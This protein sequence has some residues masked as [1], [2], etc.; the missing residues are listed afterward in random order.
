MLPKVTGSTVISV[1]VAVSMNMA[2]KHQIIKEKLPEYLVA[3]KDSDKGRQSK[4]L[5]AVVEVTGM[6][7]KSVIRA[8]RE[9]QME[10]HQKTPKKRGR[11]RIFTNDCVAA[12]NEV[13]QCAHKICG[14]RLHCCISEYVNILQRDNMWSYSSESTALLLRMSFGSVKHY[15]AQ[16]ARN[17]HTLHRGHSTTK[18]SELKEIIPIRRGPWD[19]PLPGYGEVDTVVHCGLTLFGDYCYSTQYTDVATCWCLLS[20]QWNKGQEA[21]VISIEAM[22]SR[23]PFSVLGLDP[24]SGSEFINWHMKGWCDERGIELTRIRP[25]K[26]NDHARIEQKNRTCIRDYVGYNRLDVRG[27]EILLNELYSYLELYIN[28][29]QPTM[30]YTG[31]HINEHGKTTRR[32]YDRARTPYERVLE[33]SHVSDEVKQKLREVHITLNPKTLLHRVYA[34]H[35]KL[36]KMCQNGK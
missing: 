24:D 28:H 20:G 3:R 25:G 21:T 27:S 33:H 10:S 31:K 9:K 6:H 36:L 30:K 18:P 11:K 12:L 5:D 4:I 8:F 1:T 22:V 16:F 13:W 35:E 26:K 7:R 29:F 34:L 2:T 19:N 32:I 17:D 15:C 23:A 14:E